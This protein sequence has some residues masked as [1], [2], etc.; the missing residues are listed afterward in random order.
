MVCR[1]QSKNAADVVPP[2]PSSSEPLMSPSMSSEPVMPTGYYGYNG[3][4]AE[5]IFKDRVQA[6]DPSLEEWGVHANDIYN[7]H[8]AWLMYSDEGTS[9]R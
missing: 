3:A 8:D 1:F 9:Q 2:D 5:D 7:S 4:V 6:L